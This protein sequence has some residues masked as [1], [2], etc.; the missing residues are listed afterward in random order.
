MPLTTKST[1]QA[2]L[3]K[4]EDQTKLAGQSD[5]RGRH[6]ALFWASLSFQITQETFICTVRSITHWSGTHGITFESV[7]L[8]HHDYLRW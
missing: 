8:Y 3:K 4:K 6:Y 1:Q 5:N 2:I 7:V